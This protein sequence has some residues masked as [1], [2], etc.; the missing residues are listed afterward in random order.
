MKLTCKK[1]H[2]NAESWGIFSFKTQRSNV[3][4]QIVPLELYFALVIKKV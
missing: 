1:K 3:L 2:L 4:K